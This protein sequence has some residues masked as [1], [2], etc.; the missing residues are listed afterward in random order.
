MVDFKNRVTYE[1]DVS[2]L[3][4][5]KTAVDD[6]ARSE[7]TLAQTTAT[8]T[9]A[10]TSRE[11]SEVAVT[12]SADAYVRQNLAVEQ[13]LA[14]VAKGE[15]LLRDAQ[16]QGYGDLEKLTAAVAAA[17]V[18]HE[19]LAKATEGAAGA[20]SLNRIQMMELTHVG[21][22]LF[23]QI[24]A[25]ASPMRA[26]QVEGGRIVQIFTEG[27]GGVTGTLR[28][29]GSAVAG[30]ATGWLGF[31]AAVA[32]GAGLAAAA[33]LRFQSQQDR[34]ALS[35]NGAG[36]YA[37]ASTSGLASIANAAGARNPALGQGGATDLTAAFAGTGRISSG[38]MPGLLDLATPYARGTGQDIGKAGEE[39]AH[40]FAD[41][42]RGAETLNEKLG[43]LDASTRHLIESYM[44]SGNVLGAQ[45]AL[46]NKAA[47]AAARM[48]D[49]TWL[50]TR[51]WQGFTDAVGRS[52]NTFAGDVER[53]INPSLSDKMEAAASERLMLQS[54]LANAW[55]AGRRGQVQG[56]IAAVDD[57]LAGL[58]L[59]RG[60]QEYGESR[61]LAGAASD[62]AAND[63]SLA[64]ADAI[65]RA[66]PETE[67]AN[68][69]RDTLKLLNDALRN[70]ETLAKVPGGA[71]AVTTAAGRVGVALANADPLQRIREDATLSAQA[72]GALTATQRTLIEAR[73][74]ELEVL[75]STH[76]ATQAAAK[77]LGLWNTEIARSNREAEDA[78]RTANQRAGLIGL[79]PLQRALRQN[80]YRYE[81]LRRNTVRGVVGA[82]PP[83]AGDFTAL[84]P[85]GDLA[86]ASAAFGGKRTGRVTSAEDALRIGHARSL[87]PPRIDDH[88]AVPVGA[89]PAIGA[90]APAA[91]AF[92]P[93]DIVVG[94]S[95]ATFGQARAVDRG[96]IMS[97]MTSERLREASEELERNR[98]LLEA[99][100]KAI[101]LDT[102]ATLKAV[103]AQEN[104][105][106]LQLK[107]SDYAVLGTRRIAELRKQNDDLSASQARF[108]MQQQ[109]FDQIAGASNWLRET[110][111]GI[112]SAAG[113]NFGSLFNANP[114]DLVSQ[115]GV[116]DQAKFYGGQLSGGQVKS[117]VFRAQMG[118]FLRNLMFQQ[119]IGLIQRGLFGAGQMGTPGYQS[120]LL[121]GLFNGL[122][123]GLGGGEGGGGLGGLFSLFSGGFHFANGGVMTA[124]GPLPLR[125]YASGG[126]A[127]APQLAMYGEGSSPEAYVPLP[128][129]RRIPV[130]MQGGGPQ[131]V[132]GGD[133]HFHG[134]VDTATLPQ[135][136]AMLA[137]NTR[138]VQALLL[139]NAGAT[140]AKWS[141]RHGG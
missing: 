79:S 28:A 4:R 87:E 77:S 132:R 112:V 32:T 141:Q 53:A 49:R 86:P 69:L 89:A 68:D 48:S 99:R 88:F 10:Q 36:R 136:Q 131:I 93:G 26:L 35:L 24:A 45:E 17:R 133:M 134:G 115:L 140:S 104:W 54:S 63:L 76:D 85:F 39:L 135:V 113:S 84:D 29:M 71:G 128:D 43:F 80:D 90:H 65:K 16:R 33:V 13:A 123:G 37:G 60:Y 111:G 74:A 11:R 117:M 118:D 61:A 91:S 70:P 110:G 125:R 108:D 47:D 139:R 12:R 72:A 96:A 114:R 137:E 83:G 56:Q 105:N 15:Q 31:G 8:V 100:T 46:L 27:P 92:A 50:L 7:A 98:R 34:L 14:R 119:G 122:L 64:V 30:L 20:M 23:D 97:E 44:R 25:G 95:G 21:K 19:E 103:H 62:K 9:Q 127:N 73:R 51:I 42:A 22:S 2:G 6:L 40:A 138:Q 121:G 107:A 52:A 106:S 94:R 58:R 82:L 38:L 81:E 67:N 101:G 57:R 5:A 124:G 75:R 120:G 1:A 18:K 116:G 126:V 55:T 41:P 66:V 59:G 78:L 102:E 130:A 109:R 3:V 129:G